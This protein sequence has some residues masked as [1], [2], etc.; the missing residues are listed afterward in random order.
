M[1]LERLPVAQEMQ[2]IEAIAHIRFSCAQIRLSRGDHEK[3]DI[4][5]IFDE[6]NEAFEISLKLQ[7]PDFIGATGNLLG[8]VF[9]LGGH[10]DEAVSVLATAAAAFEKIGQADRAAQCRQLIEQIKG[11]GS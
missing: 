3:G 1:H 10:P 5:T 8:Q 11:T 7:R 6:L 9:A 2:D 4:Q